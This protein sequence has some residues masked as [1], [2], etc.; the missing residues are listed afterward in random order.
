MWCFV[1]LFLVFNTSAVNYLERL[2]S[3]MTYYESSGTL[4]ST[5]SL[6]RCRNVTELK[7]CTF[8]LEHAIIVHVC[9]DARSCI[10][11]DP[12]SVD[13]FQEH[14]STLH[15]DGDYLLSQE[16]EVR[17]LNQSHNIYF[18]LFVDTK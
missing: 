14:V 3:E 16:Y 6:T 12:I 13:A 8:L 5:H 15:A 10:H 1:S 9:V 18:V 17:L 7:E 11:R 4:N 2:V